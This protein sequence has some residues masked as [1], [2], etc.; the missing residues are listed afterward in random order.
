MVRQSL[1]SNQ[2]MSKGLQR[3]SYYWIIG[4]EY[5]V[6]SALDRECG[7]LGSNFGWFLSRE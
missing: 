5:G 1:T 3:N 6:D 2:R 7:D 4:R